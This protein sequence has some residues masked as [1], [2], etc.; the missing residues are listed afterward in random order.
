MAQP[1]VWEA[2][3][4]GKVRKREAP[5]GSAPGKGSPAKPE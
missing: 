4:A 1:R 5:T 2:V 3:C